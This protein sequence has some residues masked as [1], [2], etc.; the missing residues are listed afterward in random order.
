M[1]ENEITYLSVPIPDHGI[2]LWGKGFEVAHV[3]RLPWLTSATTYYWGDLD[4]HGFAILDQLRAYLPQTQS[5]L[6]DR[7]TLL[8]HRDR[9]GAEPSPTHARLPRLTREEVAL[10][11]DL[12]TDHLGHRVRLEQERI[13]WAWATDRLASTVAISSTGHAPGEEGPP[14]HQ[15]GINVE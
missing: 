1:V 11:D 7:A 6:M 14:H 8:K 5:F 3:G 13:D 9:W 12:V 2:V 4:T 10:Y 15:S